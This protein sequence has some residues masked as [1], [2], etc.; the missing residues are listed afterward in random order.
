[1]THA[2]KTDEVKK[3]WVRPPQNVAIWT[4]LFGWIDPALADGVLQEMGVAVF[5]MGFNEV[6][7]LYLVPEVF[8]LRGGSFVCFGEVYLEIG[9]L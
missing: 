9:F 8:N 2:Q 4:I 1:M 3:P 7:T 6:C 5:G